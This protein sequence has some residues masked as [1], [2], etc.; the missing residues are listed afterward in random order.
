MMGSA[1]VHY[2][3]AAKTEA[4]IHGGVALAHRVAVQSGL[5][6]AIN[7]RV[8]VLK[9][10]C[11]Y[12]ESDHVL[13]MAFNAMCGGQTLDD[14]ELRRNDTAFL[15]AL[16]TDAIPDPTTAG[17]FCRRFKEGDIHALMTAID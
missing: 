1:K 7:K 8:H 16:Q 2:E 6:A 17:D 4:T 5:I 11:P 15:N 12:H 14:I 3:V 13:N 10:H 9:I